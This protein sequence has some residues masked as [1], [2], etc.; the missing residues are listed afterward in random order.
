MN[1]TCVDGEVIHA[2]LS[3][4]DQHLPEQVPGDVG[5]HPICPLQGLVDGHCPHLAMSTHTLSAWAT[6]EL[7]AFQLIE[8][9]AD[10]QGCLQVAFEE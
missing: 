9:H 3:L 5:H 7:T 6:S 4:L 2:L 8:Q 10:D 1:P